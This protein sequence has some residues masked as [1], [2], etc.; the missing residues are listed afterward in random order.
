MDLNAMTQG[1]QVFNLEITGVILSLVI[2][3]ILSAI[4]FITFKEVHDEMAYDESFNVMLVMISLIS[5]LMIMII[6]SSVAISLGMAGTLSLV[7]FRTNIKDNRDIGF[8]FL[9]M[10]IGITSGT[11]LYLMG[12]LGTLLL[13]GLLFLT[14]A[15]FKNEGSMLLVIRGRY[16][17]IP[18]IE[19]TLSR[20]TKVSTL[21]A[22]NLMDDSFELVYDFKGSKQEQMYLAQVIKNHEG[23]DTV[24][25]LA[26]SAEFN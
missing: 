3:G 6:R 14:G 16:A 5:T 23:V 7:R 12:T 25:I 8:V 24:N 20:Y 2:T 17:D 18:H 26:P 21:K 1:V 10:F 4:M 13:S 11:E 9:S 15:M 19:D 22:H